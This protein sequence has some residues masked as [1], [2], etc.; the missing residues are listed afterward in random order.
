MGDSSGWVYR[1][2][3]GTET[4]HDEMH[5]EIFVVETTL[6]TQVE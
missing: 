1:T 6:R 5:N 2:V 4:A 3:S